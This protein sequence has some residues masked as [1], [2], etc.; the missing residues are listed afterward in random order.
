MDHGSPQHTEPELDALLRRN[1]PEPDPAWV[2]ATG[3]RLLPDRG[4]RLPALRLAGGLVAGLAAAAVGLSL[5]GVGPIA[6]DGDVV[7]AGD[8][9]R[10]VTVERVQRVPTIATVDGE[11]RVRFRRERVRRTVE[12]CD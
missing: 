11:L 8:D 3:E 2:R 4:R 7:E 1:R 6:D 9:C 5:A 12:R 10:P